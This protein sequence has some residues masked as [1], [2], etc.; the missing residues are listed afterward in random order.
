MKIFLSGYYG[1]KNFGDELLLLKVIEDI[2]KIIPDAEFFVWSID[3]DFT[4]DF[5]K[6]YPAVA[7][8]RFN[9]GDTVNAI[10]NSDLVVLG[11]GGIVQEYYGIKIED[12]FK[13]FGYN[14]VSYA[15]PPFLG[16]IFGKKVFYWCLGHG[17]IV[18]EEAIL[19]SRW[20]YSLAD[21]VTIRDE[22]S[23]REVLELLP[24]GKIFF[25]T[26]PLFDFNFK[27]FFAEK[28][29]REV[30]G[31]SI[32][33]WFNEEELVEKVGG[34]LKRLVEERDLR[35]LPIPCD[36]TLDLEVTGRLELFVPKEKL[37]KPKIKTIEDIVSA[38]SLCNWFLGMR[39]HS[40]IC[41]YKLGIPFLAL[42]YDAKTEE[43]LRLTRGE[44]V[45]VVDFSEEE[46][47]FKLKRLLNSSPLPQKEFSY[48]TPE[49][50]LAFIEDSPLPKGERSKGI[51]SDTSNV[52]YIQDFIKTLLKQ[53]E[54][55]QKKISTLQGFIHELERENEELKVKIEKLRQ[56]RDFYFNKLDEIYT[57][58]FWKLARTYYKIR[59]NTFLKHIYRF[60]KSRPT[61]KFNPYENLKVLKPLEVIVLDRKAR[62][63][64]KDV[65]FSVITPV[66]NEGKGVYDFLCK[67]K[68][69]TL[70]PA[71][72]VIIENSSTDNTIDEI[73]R[74]INNYGK[75]L[76]VKLILSRERSLAKDRNIGI[77]E[78][79]NEILILLD[80]GIEFEK[81]LLE[82]ILATYS[83]FPG[84]DLI[85][86]IYKV[87]KENKWA[88]SFVWN[89]QNID[90]TNYIPSSRCLLIKKSKALSIGGYPEFLPYTG[91]D[92]LFAIRYRKVS[93]LWII[94]KKIK[95]LWH[96]PTT[97]GEAIRKAFLYGWGDGLIG[98][99]EFRYYRELSK[100]LKKKWFKHI[101]IKH[102][103]SRAYFKGFLKGR[104]ERNEYLKDYIK[105]VWLILS[106]VPF[107]DSGGGQRGTQ[108]ALELMKNKN[109]VVFCNVYPSFEEKKQIFLDIE[110]E[111]LELY[112]IKDFKIED[113]FERHKV[114]SQKM[115]IL[116]EVPHPEFI[117]IIKK[118]KSL[119]PQTKVI[120]DC[121]DNWDSSLGWIWYKKEV[122]DEVINLAD[123]ITAS[124]EALRERIQN[125]T[126]KPVY[127]IPNAVNTRIFKKDSCYLPPN[128]LPKGKPIVIYV[129]AMWGEWFDWDLLY[130]IAQKLNINLVLIGNC[131]QEK[132]LELKNYKNIYYLGLKPQFELPAYLSK[133]KVALIPFKYDDKIVKYT[134][135]LKVYEYLAMGLPVV[136]TY[137]DELINLPYVFL[138]KNCE[139]F[140][141]N[142][143]EA[144]NVVVD[145]TRLKEF[146]EVHSW[147]KRIKDLLKIVEV[148]LI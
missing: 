120:Y 132:V 50:F 74:F 84:S 122:E 104:K 100:W 52:S 102:T 97:R 113:F 59:D 23:Y 93:N 144:L 143:R 121:I 38:I 73:K 105:S 28:K 147:S 29:E 60:L 125:M 98:F 86:G 70:K 27:R 79:S 11:G 4:N 81:D 136:A 45:K 37:L 95:I 5:L 26:D 126:L 35:I 49:I 145:Y 127:L 87:T 141:E 51:K 82:N 21:V 92:T 78:A 67:I 133:A 128:D 90:Y 66:K 8:D 68:N 85:T 3:K 116:L 43:F 101:F 142:L 44:S 119:N 34:A 1:A 48:K 39:L 33:R 112:Q 130:E 46:L 103:V 63:K 14:I 91:E 22:R 7:V 123:F 109:K 131:P 83:E 58:N 61:E 57:S 69:Q 17:P 42:S 94:N 114:F 107:T 55:L 41:A 137:M 54:E 138:S 115:V 110:P 12:L 62:L 16:K 9:I 13:D 53:R 65:K 129:G 10:K 30:L 15:I 32:R 64:N 139:E 88:N 111:L 146:I 31:I 89:W 117:P 36:L 80:A 148:N 2:L 6:D 47:F 24:E 108:I 96:A 134:N 56:E 135:P 140:V 75:E 124:A 18:T 118:I 20:F 71:E 72:V 19:F 25:D 106:L 99:G 77:K 76:N 40:L